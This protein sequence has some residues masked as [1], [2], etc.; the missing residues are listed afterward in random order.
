MSYKE[1]SPLSW[2]YSTKFVTCF[3]WRWSIFSWL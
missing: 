2:F 1:E 3:N